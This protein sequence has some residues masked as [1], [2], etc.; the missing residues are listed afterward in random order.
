MSRVEI[1]FRETPNPDCMRCNQGTRKAR[2]TNGLCNRI[3][4]TLDGAP[5]RCVGNWGQDKTR[6]LL[7]YLTIFANG[8]KKKFKGNLHYTEICSGPGRLI[9]FEAAREFDGTSIAFLNHPHAKHLTDATFIDI[10]SNALEVLQSRVEFLGLMGPKVY[11]R[12][13]D[14]TSTESIDAATS[15]LNGR[16]LHLL[17][18]DPTDMS[19]PFSTVEHIVRRLGS[20]DLL[21]NVAFGTDF[22]RNARRALEGDPSREKYERFIGSSGFFERPDVHK[23]LLSSRMENEL[24]SALQAELQLNLGALGY[25]FFDYQPVRHYYNLLFASKHQLGMKFWR[26]SLKYA[27]NSQLGLGF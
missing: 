10:D 4:S 1:D 8:M 16:G 19:L 15:H 23:I 11:V 3:S 17:F 18:I 14:Y 22:V 25:K 12:P 9:D 26:E 2:C 20:V 7:Q 6:F 24:K 27:P 13:G 21:I 5:L